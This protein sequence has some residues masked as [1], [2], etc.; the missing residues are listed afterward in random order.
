MI[1]RTQWV[2]TCPA[3]A[4]GNAAD[5]D[6]AP[7]PRLV[8]NSLLTRV[9]VFTGSALFVA[10]LHYVHLQRAYQQGLADGLMHGHGACGD[11]TLRLGHDTG[12]GTALISL[13]NAV[14]RNDQCMLI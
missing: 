10:C 13:K 9:A 6:A 14:P 8:Q 12:A 7:A 5:V 11:A 2:A 1:E 4:T 3:L